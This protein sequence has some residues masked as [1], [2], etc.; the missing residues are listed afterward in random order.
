V[1]GKLPMQNNRQNGFTLIELLVVVAIIAILAALLLP[2]LGKAKNR[3][4]Q[5]A[6]L[7]NQRTVGQGVL[8]MADDHD[9]LCDPRTYESP[10]VVARTDPSTMNSAGVPIYYW[11][12]GVVDYIGGRAEL[13][14]PNWKGRPVAD[15]SMGFC[16][17]GTYYGFWAINAK[18]GKSREPDYAGN[19]LDDPSPTNNVR[20]SRASQPSVTLLICDLSTSRWTVSTTTFGTALTG[21]AGNR[22]G[23]RHEMRGLNFFMI[24]GHGEFI[25]QLAP[26]YPGSPVNYG[27][28]LNTFN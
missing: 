23:P 4:K 3:S 27:P 22:Y 17:G 7:N 1:S 24:D 15:P 19:P 13:V 21:G 6:C 14:Y 8:M 25:R 5:L 28:T 10:F 2:A 16:V 26:T 12:D 11:T 18:L 20:I 9:G